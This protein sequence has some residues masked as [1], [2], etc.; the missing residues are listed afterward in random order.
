MQVPIAAPLVPNDGIGPSPRISKMLNRRLSTVMLMPSVIGVRASP[1][2]RNAPLNMKKII[3]PTLKTNMMRRNGSA[4]ALTSGA[5]FTRLSKL[6]ET[7]YPMGAMTPSAIKMAVR[8][9][10]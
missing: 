3:M 2:E 9:A 6:G 10:W 1:A 4:S 8:N 7:K 5:A